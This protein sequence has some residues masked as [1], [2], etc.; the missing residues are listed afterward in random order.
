[1]DIEFALKQANIALLLDD[2]ARGKIAQTA[3]REYEVD[4]GTMKETL[5]RKKDA[6]K[7]AKQVKEAKNSPWKNAS[8]VKYPLMTVAAIQFNARAMPTLIPERSVAKGKVFGSDAGVPLVQ[9]GQI[10]ADQ[11]GNPQWVQPPG[12]K[13]ERA[14]RIAQYMSYQVLEEMEEWYDDTDTLMIALPVCETMYRKLWFDPDKERPCSKILWPDEMIVNNEVRDLKTAA[15]T[16]EIFKLYRYQIKERVNSGLFLDFNL[17]KKKQEDEL[18]EFLE[19]HTRF[20]LDNDGYPEPY[21]AT[22]HKETKKLARLTARFDSSG[23][24]RGQSGEIIR[25]VPDTYYVKYWFMP[26]ADGEG[27]GMGWGSLRMPMNEAVNTLVNQLIDAGTLQNRQGGFIGRGIRMKK[28]DTKFQMGEWKTVDVGTGSVRDN[29][30]PLPV[31]QPSNVLFS[32]LG[33]MIDASKDISSVQDI[34]TGQV[35]QTTQPTTALALIEQGMRVF[36]GIY[37]RIHRAMKHELKLLYNINSKYLEDEVYFEVMDD[38]KAIA[39]EDFAKDVA[40]VPVSDPQMVSDAAERQKAEILMSQLGNP[41][42]NGLA[43]TRKFL[44]SLGITEVERYLTVPQPDPEIMEMIQRLENDRKRAD[45]TVL[46]TKFK[47][48]EAASQAIKNLA[49][50][51]NKEGALTE[52]EMGNIVSNIMFIGNYVRN[53]DNAE[54]QMERMERTPNNAGIPQGSA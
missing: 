37:K 54:R 24:R 9:N 13:R 8:N 17:P 38:L 32:L 27:M 42:I 49:D 26:D 14:D 43:V 51:K 31:T 39:R 30:V 22:V 4:L 10:V 11:Q 45:A 34:M 46:E 16:T 36:T 15:R 47:A 53:L 7:L 29:V 1:M 52:A 18:E 44:E 25:I 28:G 41:F 20:D 12:A 35:Q 23:I 21:I 33:L 40:V 2:T 50:A 19:V 48:I 3:Y 5:D 6:I